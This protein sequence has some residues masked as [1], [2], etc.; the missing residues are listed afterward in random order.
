MVIN[1]VHSKSVVYDI[2]NARD[3]LNLVCGPFFY[4]VP[5]SLQLSVSLHEKEIISHSTRYQVTP[6]FTEQDG[7]TAL[8]I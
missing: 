5:P 2:N 7:Q 6:V 3:D 4:L 8:L 1:Y